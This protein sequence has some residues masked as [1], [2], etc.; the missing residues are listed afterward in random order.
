MK[1]QIS[2]YGKE[3]VSIVI[4]FNA[5]KSSSEEQFFELLLFSCL[6]VR[7]FHN[8]GRNIVSDAFAGLLIWNQVTIELI[9]DRPKIPTAVDLLIEA[10]RVKFDEN[11]QSLPG[12]IEEEMSSI[13]NQYQ[14]DFRVKAVQ[15]DALS[16]LP[17]LIEARSTPGKKRF[18]L[19]M[20][21]D[22]EKR[23]S[24]FVLK[25]KGF[26]ILGWGTKYYASHSIVALFRFLARKHSANPNYLKRLAFV[27][28]ACGKSHMRDVISTLNQAALA[29]QIVRA[30]EQIGQ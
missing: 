19:L 30:S 22:D 13:R 14:K 21:Y 7:Q 15:N 25:H 3:E 5:S 2:Y 17:Q 1:L 4:E 9:K 8:L 29:V 26:G 27:A 10:H 23:L 11:E 24:K 20:E 28:E 18:I 16:K 6:A 12:L